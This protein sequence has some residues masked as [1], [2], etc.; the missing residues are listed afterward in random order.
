METL[1][2]FIIKTPMGTSNNTKIPRPPTQKKKIRPY[3][4]HFLSLERFLFDNLSPE[5]NIVA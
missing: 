3:L 4:M 1:G 2:N 5:A